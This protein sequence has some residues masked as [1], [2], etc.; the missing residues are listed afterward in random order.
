MSGDFTIISLQYPSIY[1]AVGTEKQTERPQEKPSRTSS[2]SRKGNSMFTASVEILCC[3]PLSF[4]CSPIAHLLSNPVVHWE[5]TGAKALSGG[6]FLYL[7]QK[8]CSSKRVESTAIL[9][10]FYCLAG[11]VSILLKSMSILLPCRA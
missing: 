11:G 6:T 8:S 2:R 4:F 5:P 10:V 1:T 9:L 7:Q 3:I